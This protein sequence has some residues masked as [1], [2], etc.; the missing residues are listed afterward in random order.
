MTRGKIPRNRVK[1]EETTFLQLGLG[2]IVV[3]KQ[4]SLSWYLRMLEEVEI[5]LALSTDCRATKGP[6]TP[7]Y[8]ENKTEQEVLGIHV[9]V[10][11]KNLKLLTPDSS[12]LVMDHSSCPK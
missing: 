11:S 12:D 1:W 5:T 6:P 2:S 3:P 7:N 8:R 10:S 9:Q 4:Y